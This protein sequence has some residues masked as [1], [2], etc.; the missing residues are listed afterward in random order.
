VRLSVEAYCGRN[1]AGV[2]GFLAQTVGR[3]SYVFAASDPLAEIL[4]AILKDEG[5]AILDIPACDLSG[6]IEIERA[7]L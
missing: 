3:R 7:P 6:P 2:P 5:E 1:D 4:I